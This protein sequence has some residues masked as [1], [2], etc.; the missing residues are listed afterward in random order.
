MIFCFTAFIDNH[1]QWGGLDTLVL[2]ELQTPFPCRS[3]EFTRA[4]TT[5]W[6]RYERLTH[7]L[8]KMSSFPEIRT[9]G[10]Q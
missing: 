8:L 2:H 5:E 6:D 1:M 3:F 4:A 10:L 7:S 9:E